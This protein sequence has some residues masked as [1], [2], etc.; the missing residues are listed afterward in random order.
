MDNL[1]AQQQIQLRHNRPQRRQTLNNLHSQLSPRNMS[2]GRDAENCAAEKI[3]N[4]CLNE[5][6]KHKAQI[7]ILSMAQKRFLNNQ[8]QQKAR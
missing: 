3:T 8:D 1:M 4:F 7:A 6:V 2:G 5:A